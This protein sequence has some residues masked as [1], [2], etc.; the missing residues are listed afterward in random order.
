MFLYSAGGMSREGMATY[1]N[2]LDQFLAAVGTHP[3]LATTCKDEHG[4]FGDEPV[5]EADYTA[6]AY[7]S[8][9]AAHQREL[10]RQKQEASGTD[11]KARFKDSKA[12]RAPSTSASHA[13]GNSS[14]NGG[15]NGSGNAVPVEYVFWEEKELDLL[16]QLA[17]EAKDRSGG[18]QVAA[19][20]WD[21]IADKLGTGRQGG[22]VRSRYDRH[23]RQLEE[24]QMESL[25]AAKDGAADGGGADKEAG[26]YLGWG[27]KELKDMSK[28]VTAEM[29][30]GSGPGTVD[31]EG[32]A[33]KLGTNRKGSAVRTRWQRI[34][35]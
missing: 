10:E 20:E 12:A 31:W 28:L 23:K 16:V 21:V 29:S 2:E 32:V 18:R 27:E 34:R 22:A 7:R 15:S 6:P 33:K 17:A 3:F 30:R 14:G 5:E 4:V 24:R 1:T 13:A 8:G 25:A 26:A 11:G 9:T 19:G 35:K